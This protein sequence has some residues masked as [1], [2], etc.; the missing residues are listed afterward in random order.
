VTP[1]LSFISFEIL[2]SAAGAVKLVVSHV[3]S[4]TGLSGERTGKALPDVAFDE[5]S[6]EAVLALESEA[7]MSFDELPHAAKENVKTTANNSKTN[8]FIKSSSYNYFYGRK[9]IHKIVQTPNICTIKFDSYARFLY[10][11]IVLKLFN[12]VNYQIRDKYRTFFKG[13]GLI[14]QGCTCGR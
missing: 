13:V 9:D 3:V 10:N 8:L 7:G 4:V 1:S 6:V 14:A 11:C 2:L 5:S 12:I